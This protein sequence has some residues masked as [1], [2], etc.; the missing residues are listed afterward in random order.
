MAETPP[1]KEQS[2]I[3]FLHGMLQRAKTWL[4]QPEIPFGSMAM[5]SGGVRNRLEK[6]YGKDSPLLND[7]PHANFDRTAADRHFVLSKR[8]AAVRRIVSALEA[9]P[10][11]SKSMLLGKKIFI[12][13]GRSHVWYQLKDFI[14]T[15]LGLP[16]DEFNIEPAAG[17]STTA[18][19]DAMLQDAGFAFVVMTAEEAHAD[20]KTYARPNVI[21]ESGLF[22]GRLGT[23]RAIVLLENGCSDFSNIA[24]L[25]QIRFPKDDM[26][27]AL[28]DVRRV[29]ER[30][31]LI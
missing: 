25:T 16:C 17:I 10:G 31:K 24:G 5:W 6:I 9:A 8:V 13:H 14:N 21:H 11:A 20:G 26:R 29:L 18:R 15:R 1:A 19:L 30:E 22:Q 4:K 7:L 12:G 2:V 27:P 3:D 23:R 28:E